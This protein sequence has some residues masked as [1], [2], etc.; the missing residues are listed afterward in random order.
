MIVSFVLSFQIKLVFVFLFCGLLWTSLIHKF[1]KQLLPFSIQFLIGMGSSLYFITLVLYY[2]LLLF[3]NYSI[4]FYLSIIILLH[5]FLLIYVRKDLGYVLRESMNI[6]VLNRLNRWVKILMI[7]VLCLFYMG[8]NYYISKK[9][10]TE[11]DTL[12]YAVQGNVFFK[13]RCINYSKHRYDKESGFYYVGLHGFSFPLIRTFENMSN[14][15]LN[16]NDLFFRSVNSIYG[17]FIILI[18][19]FVTIEKTSLLYGLIVSSALLLNYGFF[20]NIMKYHLDNYRVFFVIL[21]FYMMYVF[22]KTN[23]LHLLPLLS[24]ILG[25][26]GNIH[27]LG[28]MISIIQMMVLFFYLIKKFSWRAG[29]KKFL[30]VGLLAMLFGGVHYLIDITAGTGWI[31]KDIKF[32]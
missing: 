30:I 12:E 13:D 9:F 10:V 4:E 18:I 15:F 28:F 16:S 5:V 22:L 27:S 19:M 1:S 32:Y 2:L 23:S 20:E 7:L 24:F 29:V 14:K 21:S 25:A 6:S 8:W 31:F 11:H 26:Q 3:C 17:L